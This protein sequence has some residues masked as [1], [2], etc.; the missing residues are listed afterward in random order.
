MQ[1]KYL[2]RL[3]ALTTMSA[4]GL[5]AALAL[6]TQPA[7]AYT[8]I[9]L[10]NMGF[11]VLSINLANGCH[12]YKVGW[13]NDNKTDLGSDCAPTFQA[14]LDAFV[15]SHCPPYVCPGSTVTV[16]TTATTMQTTTVTQTTTETVTQPAPPAV[17]T[18]VAGVHPSY[19]DDDPAPAA[20]NDLAPYVAPSPPTASFTVS[21]NGLAVTVTDTSGNQSVTW[22]FGD[23]A[24]GSGPTVSNAYAHTGVY[25]II[26]TVVDGNGLTAQTARTVT[27]ARL[28]PLLG[29]LLPFGYE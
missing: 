6:T 24:N 9:D 8:I 10:P 14:N 25:T 12:Q 3:A 5:I 15:A 11:G 20:D 27:V 19:P 13:H 28:S 22:N 16:A 17:T 29:K 23:G 2:T 1:S 26:E 21:E 18:T 7:R 4:A